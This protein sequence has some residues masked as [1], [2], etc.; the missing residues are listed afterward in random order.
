MPSRISTPLLKISANDLIA[1]GPEDGR[2]GE[3]WGVGSGKVGG[4]GNCH[5]S[6]GAVRVLVFSLKPVLN[7][8]NVCS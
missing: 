6:G 1:T 8:A 4:G 3:E 2:G 7:W 5:E